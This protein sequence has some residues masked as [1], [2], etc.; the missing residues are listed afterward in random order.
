MAPRRGLG[1]LLPDAG[2]RQKLRIG[3]EHTAGLDDELFTRRDL[4]N[5]TRPELALLPLI[6]VTVKKC[7]TE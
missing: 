4:C 1:S 6:D 5:D 3:E 7:R 2:W